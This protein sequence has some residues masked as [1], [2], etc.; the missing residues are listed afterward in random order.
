MDF[1][2]AAASH[3]CPST[4]LI[5]YHHLVYPSPSQHSWL[6]VEK[7]PNINCDKSWSPPCEW[8]ARSASSG[9]A[10]LCHTNFPK[11]AGIVSPASASLSKVSWFL[12]HVRN[13]WQFLTGCSQSHCSMVTHL[14]LILIKNRKRKA[15]V[16]SFILL[17]VNSPFLHVQVS[18]F[19][20]KC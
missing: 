1:D 8:S 9:N 4:W 19:L 12:S 6:I 20:R 2:R 5:R 16:V 17:R 15:S 13:L 11:I 10:L 18:R 7:F 3:A 14:H